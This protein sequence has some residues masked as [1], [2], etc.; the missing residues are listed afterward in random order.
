[1]EA[2]AVGVIL[3]APWIS[4]SISPQ[5]VSNPV[6]RFVL[7]AALVAASQ[8]PFPGILALLAV[9]TLLTERS[10]EVLSALP[11]VAPMPR[12]AAMPMPEPAP[13]PDVPM[14]AP[15]LAPAPVQDHPEFRDSNPRLEAGPSSSN[16]P[17]FYRLN[18]IT[19]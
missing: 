3:G 12:K 18:G 7:L 19:G 8:R 16:A 5:W 6:A 15:V 10:H 9:F 11:G 1:M 2:V 4:A 14:P 13:A 17:A